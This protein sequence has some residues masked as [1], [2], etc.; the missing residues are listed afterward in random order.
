MLGEVDMDEVDLEHRK[1]GV[2][3]A[4]DALQ[5]LLQSKHIVTPVILLAVVVVVVVVAVQLQ[6]AFSSHSTKGH[7]R[8]VLFPRGPA[9][10]LEGQLARHRHRL[11]QG[12]ATL[13]ASILI[14]RLCCARRPSYRVLHGE[15]HCCCGRWWGLSKGAKREFCV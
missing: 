10:R 4:W 14:M 8:G 15:H 7:A 13:T 11:P 2:H 3:K 1:G 12:S 9:A 5:V 6:M